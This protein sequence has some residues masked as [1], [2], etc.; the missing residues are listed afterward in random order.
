VNPNGVYMLDD[1]LAR[2]NA[3]TTRVRLPATTSPTPIVSATVHGSSGTSTGTSTRLVSAGRFTR[4]A[5]L[6]GLSRYVDNGGSCRGGCQRQRFLPLSRAGLA[7]RVKR[8][9]NQLALHRGNM[10]SESDH[11]GTAD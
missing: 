2:P 1:S 8:P 11:H 4:L 7:K 6:Y 3:Q 10:S 5:S 9:A